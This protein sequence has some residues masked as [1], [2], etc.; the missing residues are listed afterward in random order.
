MNHRIVWPVVLVLAVGVAA[1]TI[2]AS[3]AQREGDRGRPMD[4]LAP[5]QPGRFVV[6]KVFDPNSVLLLDT[7]TGQIYELERSDFKKA[8]SLPKFSEG[9]P[10]F[11]REEPMKK[12]FRE[13]EERKKEKKKEDPN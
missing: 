9:R 1:V 7:A 4:R 8:S 12:D 5:A 2:S 11:G 13:R 10:M 6:A 3:N